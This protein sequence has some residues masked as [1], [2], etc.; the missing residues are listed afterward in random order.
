[1]RYVVWWRKRFYRLPKVSP[2]P[3]VFFECDQTLAPDALVE[4][5]ALSGAVTDIDDNPLAPDS[6]YLL[7]NN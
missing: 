7:L 5:T 3:A 4:Q 6:L 1:M 2:F